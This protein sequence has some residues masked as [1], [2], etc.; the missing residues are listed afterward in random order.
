MAVSERPG[1]RDDDVPDPQEPGHQ[2]RDPAGRGE[3]DPPPVRP[4]PDPRN[5]SRRRQWS[6]TSECLY[7]LIRLLI[8][9]YGNGG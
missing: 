1:D 9:L 4:E 5:A 7:W 6:I 2:V 8:D 3:D